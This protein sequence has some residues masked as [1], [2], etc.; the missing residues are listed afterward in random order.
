MDDE[1]WDECSLLSV[2]DTARVL[3]CSESTVRRAV[4]E[5]RVVWVRLRPHGHI[6]ILA[7]SLQRLVE[8][9]LMAAA[10]R[11]AEPA[12]DPDLLAELV[13]R[14]REDAER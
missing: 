9:A 4:R 13:R 10:E 2:A 5:H 7:G 12:P 11:A 14:K 8:P 6:R 3:H 1:H